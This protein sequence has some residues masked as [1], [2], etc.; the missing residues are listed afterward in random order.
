LLVTGKPA[1]AESVQVHYR[2]PP[3][4]QPY[5]PL[6][7]PGHDEFPEEKAAMELAARLR[8]WWAA[9]GTR[10]E[11]R[12]YVLPDDMVRFEIKSPGTYKTGLGKVR[13]EGDRVSGITTVEEYVASAPRP[14]FRDV[15]GAVFQ[16]VPSFAEQL[17]RGV[18]YWISRL[19][20]ATGIQ[21]YGSHG[22]AVGDIDND[23]VDEV[24]VCQ[25]GGLPNR[26]YRNVNGRFVDISEKAG[27][28]LLDETSCALFLD[29][30]N[31]GLQD[32]VCPAST[33]SSD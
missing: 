25:P 32:V 5:I 4:Y 1:Y 23:G 17:S 33:T 16:G 26:L 7:E 15:T 19:D 10:G 14:L 28:D 27:I 20:P 30:R 11:A 6:M 12:F 13:F 2:R 24:Y 3:P 21:I 31:A 8:E 18:P 22:I 9:Q 29:L